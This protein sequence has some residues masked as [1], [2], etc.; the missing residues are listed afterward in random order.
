MPP[1]SPGQQQS[2]ERRSAKA[3]SATSRGSSVGW[4]TTVAPEQATGLLARIYRQAMRRAGKVFHVL[5]IQSLR[6]RTLD[7][8]TRLYGEVM[9]ATDSPLTR[10]QRE[11]LATA[12]SQANDCHY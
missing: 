1:T 10:L 6:P 2:P 8:S 9:L 7:A 4:I 5:R 12:V 11:M 3:G